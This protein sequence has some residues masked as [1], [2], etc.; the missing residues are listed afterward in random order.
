MYILKL[1]IQ[2]WVVFDAFVIFCY[3]S[4]IDTSMWF[5]VLGQVAIRVPF[6]LGF[7]FVDEVSAH[8][9][10]ISTAQHSLAPHRTAPHRTASTTPH[11]TSPH[12]AALQRTVCTA[13]HSTAPCRTAQCITYRTGSVGNRSPLPFCVLL[14]T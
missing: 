13:Q 12:C 5:L 11:R 3:T 4:V 9:K 1:Y 10:E 8:R 6:Q 2:I 14:S 7:L